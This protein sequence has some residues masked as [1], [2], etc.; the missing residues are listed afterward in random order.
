MA[1]KKLIN[2]AHAYNNIPFPSNMRSAADYRE[3]EK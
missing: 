2:G 3:L 1:S